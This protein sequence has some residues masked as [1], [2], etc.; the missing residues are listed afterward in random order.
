[1][2]T[3][4]FVSCIVITAFLIPASVFAQDQK[5]GFDLLETFPGPGTFWDFGPQPIPADFFGPGSD[6]FDGQIALTGNPPVVFP[7]AGLDDFGN[8]NMIIERQGILNF[9]LIPSSDVIPIEIV[10]LELRSVAPIVVTGVGPPELWDVEVRVSPSGPSAGTMNATKTHQNGGT[11]NAVILVEPQFVFIRQS[12]AQMVVLD[13]P[14]DGYNDLWECV[15]VPWTIFSGNV[16]CL[17]PGCNIALSHDGAKVTSVFYGTHSL[18]GFTN[19]CP[20]A[21]PTLSSLGLIVVVLLLLATGTVL[22]AR[23][24][25]KVTVS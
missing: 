9:P 22:M 21:V 25:R 23:R 14:L 13:G 20:A 10:A 24:R 17:E 8:S 5:P 15:N 18:H 1:M 12:D 4:L 6:P 3:R 2:R 11:F 7:P 19:G 16:N